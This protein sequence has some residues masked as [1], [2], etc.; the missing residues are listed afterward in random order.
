MGVVSIGFLAFMIFTSN[1]FERI[2]PAA[3]EGR[4]LNPLL[5]DFGLIVH[6]PMLYMGYVG[7]A[8]PF[9]FAIAALLDRNASTAR[10]SGRR[11]AA[12]DTALDQCRLGL[13]DPG[14]RAGQLVGVLRTGLGRLVVL[15]SGRER[16]LHAVARGRGAAA[17]AGDHREARQLP[18]LDPAAGHRHVLAVAAGHLPRALRRADQRAR[19]RRR[20]GARPVHPD[21]PRPDRRRLAAA[22]C[23]ARGRCA[24]QAVRR[25]VARN[26]A[27]A[28]Q[29]LPH[30]RLRDGAD[31]HALSAAARRD[32]QRGQ[33]LGRSAVLL[34]AV[35]RADAAD[36]AAGAAPGR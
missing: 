24:G 13:P 23:A 2:L 12:L 17:L 29:R 8:V 3:A 21:L 15:G 26:A 25:P 33:D 28:Q 14:H 34:A 31:R 22:V 9:A 36:R 35:H 19:V 1:P 18:Q 11:L 16:Q 27:A 30:R 10:R 32:R 6:P 7:F 5:Q 4:D 20:S